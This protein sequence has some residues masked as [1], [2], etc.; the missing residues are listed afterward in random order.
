MVTIGESTKRERKELRK[1]KRVEQQER[2]R[3]ERE[4]IEKRSGY[5][6]FGALAVILILAGFFLLNRDAATA[7]APKILVAPIFYDFGDVSLAGGVVSTV[8]TIKN[9]G[10][11]DLVLNDM[12][13][14]CGCTTA[15]VSKDEKEGPVFGMRMHGTNPV[16]WSETL[17]SGETA[18]LNIYYDPEVHPELRGPVT[19]EIALFSNDP[20]NSVQVIRIDVNQVD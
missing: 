19:R 10:G 8:M 14:S 12:D 15:S 1:K 11:S 18:L 4:K 5:M 7:Q 13:S 20:K 16:G 3:K 6:K 2:M 9:E 17:K